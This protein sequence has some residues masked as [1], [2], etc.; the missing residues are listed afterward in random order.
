MTVMV[1]CGD[2]LELAARFDPKGRR[3]VAITDPIWPNRNEKLW[4]GVDAY[5]LLNGTLEQLV[6]KVTHVVIQVG[7]TTDPRF[8]TAVPTHWPFWRTCWLRYHQPT[9]QGQTLMSGDVAYVFGPT[10]YPQGGR[11][12]PGEA[13]VELAPS[14]VSDKG[15]RG[16]GLGVHPC[17]R[18]IGHVR[19][20]V[21]WFTLP[22]ETVLDMFGGSGTTAI[23]GRDHGRDV[24]VWDN[25][26]R[27]VA[28]TRRRLRQQELFEWKQPEPK[29]ESQQITL[30]MGD[31][32]RP[33]K[34]KRRA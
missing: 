1:K 4:P 30:D 2:A 21:R 23:A 11:V 7:C 14:E 5:K 25:D 27:F 6:G 18:A 29:A 10:R 19:W 13:P 16:M 12:V 26:P 20:L 8:L 9:R 24:E 15:H 34:K 28:L 17:P 3:V 31:A 22:G 32:A 33:A